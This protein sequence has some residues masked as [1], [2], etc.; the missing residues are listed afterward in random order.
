MK[1]AYIAARFVAGAACLCVAAAAPAQPTKS[2]K[3][4]NTGADCVQNTSTEDQGNG[5]VYINFRNSCGLTFSIWYETRSG[6]KSSN[7]IGPYGNSHLTV[8]AEEMG[9]DWW[10]E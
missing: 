10:V 3:D 2:Y 5:Y 7:G 8:R 1:K 4:P 9:G 6:K